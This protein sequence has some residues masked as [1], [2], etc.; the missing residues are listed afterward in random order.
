MDRTRPDFLQLRRLGRLALGPEALVLAVLVALI[1]LLGPNSS[2]DLDDIVWVLLLVLVP[3]SGF[4]LAQTRSMPLTRTLI[5]KAL[6]LTRRL[7][8]RLVLSLGLD[9]HPGRSPRPAPFKGMRRA[10]GL[11]AL[12][13]VVMLASQGL[14][15]E[16]LAATRVRGL[17]SLHVLGLAVVWAWL[18]IGIAVQL[19]AGVLVVFEVLKRRWRLDGV[20]RVFAAATALGVV[21]VLLTAL[22]AREGVRA[23]LALLVFAAVL[24]SVVSPVDPPRGPWLNIAMG[25]DG[26][27]RTTRLGSLL[28]DAHRLLALENLIVVAAL[29][30]TARVAGDLLPVTDMLLAVYAWLA[31]WLSTGGALLAVGE[32]N[33]RRRLDDPTFE[34]SKVIWALPGPEAS[35]L[36]LERDAITRAGWRLVIADRLPDIDDADLLVGAPGE[37]APSTRVPLSQVPPAIFLL[38]A[39]PGAVLD[40]AEERDKADRCTQL[41]ER[42]LVATRPRVHDRGEGTFLV[43]HCWLVMGLTRDDDRGG[44]ERASGMPFGQS[45][46]ATLGTRLRRF[47]FEVMDRAGVDVLYVED[48][49]TPEQVSEVLGRLFERHI[50]RVR[51]RAVAEHDFTGIHGVR[52]VLHDVTPEFEGV[53]GVDNAT[54]R[55]AISRARILIVG[56]DRND[57][58][59]DDDGP[60]SEG[61]SN[62]N[63]LRESLGRLFPGL[64]PTG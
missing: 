28:R 27:P 58:D 36:K 50:E 30:P 41:L 16:L 29:I 35:A 45:F 44:I 32:F 37:L 49:I 34:R 40:E 23:S 62:D 14:L 10:V 7:R 4:S 33:R 48:A 24:P 18:L 6:L 55:H 38:A 19:P 43:P 21:L 11:L 63:W 57:G 64:Q 46:Q 39:D 61:E 17:Y 9:F 42:L 3:L 25:R 47:L 60:P 59:D 53:E 31:V 1:E 54:A 22:H 12:A 52:V 51:P 15:R 20:P 8:S 26:R 5:T 56:K 2:D 13:A